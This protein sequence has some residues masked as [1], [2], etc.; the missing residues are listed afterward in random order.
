[1]GKTESMVELNMHNEQDAN[2]V[3]KMFE[4]RTPVSHVFGFRHHQS[5]FFFQLLNGVITAKVAYAPNLD[6][7][8]VYNQSNTTLYLYDIIGS[9]IPNLH[10]IASCFHFDISKVEIH[11]SPDLLEASDIKI[12]TTP[13]SAANGKRGSADGKIPY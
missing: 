2:L 5:P 4:K 9:H 8:L 11:F 6:V 1:M 3:R 12:V 10:M 13:P 7:V